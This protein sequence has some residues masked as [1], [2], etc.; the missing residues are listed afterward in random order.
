[1]LSEKKHGGSRGLRD[2]YTC[3]SAHQEE[4]GQ[5]VL[6]L[7]ILQLRPSFVLAMT[8]IQSQTR[9][10]SSWYGS[11][12]ICGLLRGQHLSSLL[13]CSL[14]LGMRAVW[15]RPERAHLLAATCFLS[16]IT[17]QTKADLAFRRREAKST[18]DQSSYTYVPNGVV[19]TQFCVSSSDIRMELRLVMD[20][21]LALIDSLL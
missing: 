6:D 12:R 10:S 14:D 5:E 18:Q 16:F 9:Y 15:S 8:S 13:R 4:E 19:I 17:H 7:V 1:M 3:C 21:R 11:Y 20:S 2:C